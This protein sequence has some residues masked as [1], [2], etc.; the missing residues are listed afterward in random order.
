MQKPVKKVL[1][2]ITKSNWGGAQRYVFDLAS[3]LAAKDHEAIVALG[4][5][6]ELQSKLQA[7]GI[8]V[9]N[10]KSLQRDVSL[11]REL[12]SIFEIA[13]LIREIRPDVLHI[14]SS[15]AGGLGA[16]IGRILR[17]PNVIFT[18]H[19]WAF[20]EDR[21]SWQ[22]LII[23][24]FHWITVLLSHRTITVS[25]AVKNQMNWPLV[26]NRMFTVHNGRKSTGFLN[27]HDARTKL[28]QTLPALSSFIDD[29]WT[30]TIG[31][32]HPV[33]RHDVTI[34]AIENLVRNG[35][36][37]IRHLVLGSGELLIQLKEL[38]EKKNLTENVF[39][40]GHIDEAAEYLKA[41]NI[42]IQPSRSEA[43]AYTVIEASQ[44]GLPIIASKVGG[45]P[46]IITNGVSGILVPS[47]NVESLTKELSSLL[48]KPELRNELAAS[49]KESGDRFSLENM[50]NKTISVYSR[51]ASV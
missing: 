29:V 48:T 25:E 23:K 16:L 44:A 51:S 3:N 24:F 6:G 46:E 22:A 11:Y 45:I 9:K 31:E 17:V 26:Q 7:I 28:S 1:F 41:F 18:A 12:Q 34:G 40:L 19:G 38:V 14:N 5:N 27:R 13:R 20:N 42:Y 15:K 32:L 50:V 37:S 21:P 8:P 30:G 2:L 33:K 43:F 4:G 47:G 39:F 49:A 36:S 10:I 35:Q